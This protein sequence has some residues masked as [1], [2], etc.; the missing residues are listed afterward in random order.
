MSKT[1]Y[2]YLTFVYISISNILYTSSDLS[3]ELFLITEFNYYNVYPCIYNSPSNIIYYGM[4]LYNMLIYFYILYKLGNYN[5][6]LLYG[7]LF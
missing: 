7:I 4:Y 5:L 2:S 3:D 1:L 6:P